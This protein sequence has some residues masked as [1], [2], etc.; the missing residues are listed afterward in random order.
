MIFIVFFLIGK[1]REQKKTAPGRTQKFA[2]E[3][4]AGKSV[5]GRTAPEHGRPMT[6]SKNPSHRSLLRAGKRLA[7]A[8][9]AAGGLSL[10]LG[11][12]APAA[13]ASG[14]AE[15]AAAAHQQAGAAEKAERVGKTLE[16]RHGH[17]AAKKAKAAENE[18]LKAWRQ[19]MALYL[20]RAYKVPQNRIEQIVD[21]AVE[22][23]RQN[24]IDPLLLLS[25]AAAESNFDPNAK[26]RRSGASGLMQVMPK[27]HARRFSRKEGGVFDIDANLQVGAE[28][29]RELIDKTG[30]LQ[31]G[32]KHY[33][34]AALLSHDAGYGNKITREHSRL[35]LAAGGEVSQAVKLRRAERPAETFEERISGTFSEFKEWLTGTSAD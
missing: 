12:A 26:N 10:A 24:D 6:H 16:P 7:A 29:L 33:V 14:S 13:L 32:L 23:G 1:E 34:G 8:V 19:N 9:L 35:K 3:P 15:A 11:L 5:P 17:E 4:P 2:Q 31:R 30:S 22:A 27:I 28:L 18:S 20:S 21:A 25:I